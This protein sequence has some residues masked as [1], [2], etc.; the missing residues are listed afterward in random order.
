MCDYRY[1]WKSLDNGNNC[2]RVS[3][4]GIDFMIF[5]V[6]HAGSNGAM[7]RK[8]NCTRKNA[9]RLSGKELMLEDWKRI[10]ECL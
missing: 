7:N 1:F 8:K 4:N 3:R 5:G 9:E 6:S 10:R 2:K